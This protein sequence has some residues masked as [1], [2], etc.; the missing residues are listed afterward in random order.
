MKEPRDSL[1]IVEGDGTDINMSPVEVHINSM[2]PKAKNKSK[3]IVI[4]E[5]KKKSK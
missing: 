3:T 4:P 5:N 1:E 2:K